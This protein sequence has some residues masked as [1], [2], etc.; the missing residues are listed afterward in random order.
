MNALDGLCRCDTCRVTLPLPASLSP[1]EVVA[2]RPPP[3]AQLAP[4]AR[5]D[6]HERPAVDVDRD[7]PLRLDGGAGAGREG[8][9][10]RE[11]WA[12]AEV[13][14][15]IGAGC[16]RNR[17]RNRERSKTLGNVPIR[18]GC[19]RN[20][21]SNRADVTPKYLEES[22]LCSTLNERANSAS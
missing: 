4:P 22:K 2:P 16:V 11:K 13:S 21:R 3:R 15:R 20:R 6:E 19:L 17:P 14:A 8:V 10:E 12:H 18:C 1:R 5:H 9:R 7:D